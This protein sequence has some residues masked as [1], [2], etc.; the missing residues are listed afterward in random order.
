MTDKPT[1]DAVTAADLVAARAD[2]TK[3]QSH[4]DWRI[5][6]VGAALCSTVVWFG[7]VVWLAVRVSGFLLT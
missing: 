4:L 5:V 3:Q 7:F 1:N 2:N 6:V